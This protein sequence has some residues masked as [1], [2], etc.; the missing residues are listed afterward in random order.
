[1]LTLSDSVF[2][3]KLSVSSKTGFN[4]TFLMMAL[5]RAPLVVGHKDKFFS[6]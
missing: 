6:F 4:C 1:M 2:R 5:D 3:E